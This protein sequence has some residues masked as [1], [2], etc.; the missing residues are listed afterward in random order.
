[1]ARCEWGADVRRRSRRRLPIFIALLLLGGVVLGQ[2]NGGVAQQ[3]ARLILRGTPAEAREV[4]SVDN[5]EWDLMGRQYA[6][7]AGG[8]VLPVSAASM[9]HYGDEGALLYLRLGNDSH[10]RRLRQSDGSIELQLRWP[11]DPS[12][13]PLTWRQRSPPSRGTVEGYEPVSV[14]LPGSRDTNTL[15]VGIAATPDTASAF[16]ACGGCGYPAIGAHVATPAGLLPGPCA[17]SNVT[18][19]QWDPLVSPPTPAPLNANDTSRPSGALCHAVSAVELWAKRPLLLGPETGP[20]GD[21]SNR[22]P[23]SVGLTGAAGCGWAGSSYHPTDA[24]L[25]RVESS[26]R[27]AAYVVGGRALGPREGWERCEVG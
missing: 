13:P 20:N 15:F 22:P 17:S 24:G 12:L 18:E 14:G 21:V 5:Q 4:A 1:M 27:Q 2:T 8:A 3:P 23:Q 6:P 11:L 19:P 16:D 25:L 26:F 7:A 9:S 10:W